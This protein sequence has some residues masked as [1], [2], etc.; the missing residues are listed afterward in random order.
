MDRFDDLTRRIHRALQTP[1]QLRRE[2]ETRWKR[3]QELLPDYRARELLHDARGLFTPAEELTKMDALLARHSR[4]VGEWRRKYPRLELDLRAARRELEQKI[5]AEQLTFLERALVRRNFRAT[6]NVLHLQ[7]AR[8][9]YLRGT[10]R[11]NTQQKA[12]YRYGELKPSTV[13]SFA[14]NGATQAIVDEARRQSGRGNPLYYEPHRDPRLGTEAELK[15]LEQAGLA[16]RVTQRVNQRVTQGEGAN[17]WRLDEAQLSAKVREYRPPRLG[18][19]TVQALRQGR[20]QNLP[21]LEAAYPRA[22]RKTRE[23]YELNAP[24]VRKALYADQAGFIREWTR[25]NGAVAD[26]RLAYALATSHASE[27]G[28]HAVYAGKDPQLTRYLRGMAMRRDQQA[29]RFGNGGTFLIDRQEALTLIERHQQALHAYEA[30]LGDPSAGRDPRIHDARIHDLVVRYGKPNRDGSW[31][32]TP[33][34]PAPCWRLHQ[35][36]A[37]TPTAIQQQPDGSYH[38]SRDAAR[39]Y[40]LPGTPAWAERMS[41]RYAGLTP[42]QAPPDLCAI[43][44][45]DP[46]AP[47]T[48]KLAHTTQATYAGVARRQAQIPLAERP[49]YLVERANELSRSAWWLEH[50]VMRRELHALEQAQPHPALTELRTGLEAM[51]YQALRDREPTPAIRTA[52]QPVTPQ[53][54]HELKA[55]LRRRGDLELHD[56]LVISQATGLRP[57]ELARG[58]ALEQRGK[59]VLIYIQGGKRA[60]GLPETEA[61]FQAARGADR[62]L[63]VTSPE[64]SEIA[65]RHQG[66]F[67][68]TS[69]PD[70]LR[71]RL[72][73]ARQGIAGGETLQFYSFRHAL[74]SQL[75]MNGQSREGIAR[76][77]GHCSMRSQEQYGLKS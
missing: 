44:S 36:A 13:Q 57:G 70:A 48:G 10:L 12:L 62:V 46:R 45:H 20:K 37:L 24:Q 30:R 3:R 63:K 17:R 7:G 60:S 39:A 28:K 6:V 27:D 31:Q 58:V 14:A 59:S 54:I 23:G 35:A 73:D 56:A 25:Q 1:R 67:R 5:K 53:A 11:L 75:E 71:A 29:V 52:R 61:R 49:R 72:R 32:A 74:K 22:C 47:L 9:S 33:S 69:T 2:Q 38:V 18:V 43:V 34:R 16:Q 66:Y 15:R 55:E 40:A 68:P 41:E 77:M 4:L 21:E 64:V 76:I 50:A 51:T 19:D 42:Q 65:K 26:H 8:R